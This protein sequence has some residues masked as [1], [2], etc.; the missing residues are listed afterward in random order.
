MEH[1]FN[2]FNLI[3]EPW[4]PCVDMHGRA[5]EKGLKEVLQEAHKTA[6]INGSTPL[7]T[8]ALIR[9]LMAVLY[10][11]LGVRDEKKW[12]EIWENG[13]FSVDIIDNYLGKFQEQFDL[14]G[15]R[16][17]YQIP[18]ME[19]SEKGSV[20]RLSHELAT[21]HNATLFDHGNDEVPLELDY[22]AAT[23]ALIVNQAFALGFGKASSAKV[24]GNII[25][26]PYLADGMALRGMILWLNGGN[27]FETLMLNLVPRGLAQD[28]SPPWELTDPMF[29][30]DQVSKG[31]RSICESKGVVDI[32]TWQPRMV[33][34]LPDAD[35]KIRQ[36]YFTQGRAKN[37]AKRD[38][39]KSYVQ[40]KTEGIYPLALHS[41]K[42]SWRD[43]HTLL[44]FGSLRNSIVTF[45]SHLISEGT[46]SRGQ[47]Y[48]LEIVGMATS[49][50]KAGKFLLWRH[51]R[52]SVPA[53]L[54]QD[55][56][57]VGL[58]ST[59][60]NEAEAMARELQARVRKVIHAFV[61]PEGNPDPDDVQKLTESINP[62]EQFWSGL[63]KHFNSL[64]TELPKNPDNAIDQWYRQAEQMA[65][66]SF[67]DACRLLGETPKTWK[68]MA[69][70]SD[71]FT[72]DPAA[73]QKKFDEAKKRKSKG[74]M[75]K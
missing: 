59:A 54:I 8:P 41:S 52:M 18:G 64:V 11:S 50:G 49:P 28:D 32:Y 16:A 36:M 26:R 4:I 15:P 47:R 29:R 24:D 25:D 45:V 30:M 31:E 3:D 37:D 72:A 14:F 1:K 27:L 38:P 35:G 22:A 44:Q 2:K 58:L 20:R 43:L 53:P 5:Q 70:V 6:N 51:D 10:C 48:K 33:R 57:L 61:P 9:F 74:G 62:T 73:R 17:F 60:V 65:K 68:A 7:E 12:S 63:E 19:M 42:A 46:L 55:A 56:E 21:G 34:L 23:R 13:R 67:L 75:Q 71:H 39:M 66:L 40:S 69:N